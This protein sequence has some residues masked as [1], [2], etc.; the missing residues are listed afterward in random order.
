MFYN[1]PFLIKLKKS[2]DRKALR[3]EGIVRSSEKGFGFLEVDSNT[4]YFIPPN[5]MKKTMNGDRVLAKVRI[6][7]D[8]EIVELEQLVDPFLKVFVGYFEKRSNEIFIVPDYPYLKK[9]MINVHNLSSRVF[10]NEG[11][12]ILAKLVKHKLRGEPIFCAEIVEF[13]SKKDNFLLPW[14]VTLMRYDLEK[15]AP[16]MCSSDIWFDSKIKR[17][18]L[19]NIDFITIDNSS[20]K[21]IDDA[22]HVEDLGSKGFSIMVAIA[23]PTAYISIGSKLDVIASKRGFTNYLPGFNIPMLPRKLSEDI[24]SLKPKVKRPAV[25]CKMTILKDGKLLKD[26]INF[27]LGWIE[28]KEKLQYTNV[29]DWIEKKGSWRPSSSSIARQLSHIYKICKIRMNWRM[30]NA[31][32]FKDRPEFKFHFSERKRVEKITLEPRRIAHRIIEELMILA[33]VCVSDVLS[34]K[35]GYGIFNSHRG[36]DPNSLD[37]IYDVLKK[38]NVVFNDIDILSFDGFCKIRRVLDKK[39]DNYLDNR[40]RKYQ[41]FGEMKNVPSPHFALGFKNY[42]TWTSPIRKYGDMLNHRLLKSIILNEQV[43][44]P[45]EKILSI[46]SE[47]K[48]LYRIAERDITEWLY[49]SFFYKEEL[50]DDLYHMEILNVMNSGLRGKLI[51]N[52]AIV[53]LPFQFLNIYKHEIVCKREEGT[54]YIHGKE[55][56]RVTN[57]VKVKI[58]EFKKENRN[59][60]VNL[61]M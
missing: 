26:S 14:I 28:S 51:E 34:K 52:G 38:N 46:M 57:I 43:K 49:F 35:L 29:S 3:V 17:L 45:S 40:L 61:I 20:T 50:T 25:V 12:W 44:K 13:V 37:Q 55:A 31:L 36:F 39:K 42:A 19:T 1:N 58:A 33:N 59:I 9:I 5:Q 27:F 32:V 60:L 11:D 48:K 8:R 18:D 22:V 2:L 4:S 30:K 53:F 6:E 21:D 41:S 47:R 7:R 10:F 16:K 54:I 23:D 15:E 56:F 24:C